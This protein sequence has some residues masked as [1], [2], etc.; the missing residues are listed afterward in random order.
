[1]NNNEQIE[2]E[3]EEQVKFTMD[4]HSEDNQKLKIDY[5]PIKTI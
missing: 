2:I 5:D 3:N 4:K 1:M